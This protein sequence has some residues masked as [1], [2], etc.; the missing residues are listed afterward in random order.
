MHPKILALVRRLIS[1]S[2]SIAYVAACALLSSTCADAGPEAPRL[3]RLEISLTPSSGTVL[4]GD[5]ARAHVH[6]YDQFD[7]LWPVG[8]VTWHAT[9]SSIAA[10]T[11]EGL[12]RGRAQGSAGIVATVDLLSASHP[13]VVAGTLHREAIRA[14]EVWAAT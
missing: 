3:D 12:V 13:I 10:I 11:A 14:S 9:D 2:M 6:G 7:N 4:Q 1:T 5:T 8:A